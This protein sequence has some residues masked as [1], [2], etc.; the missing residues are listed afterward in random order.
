MVA[1]VSV[2]CRCGHP[3]SNLIA[4]HP[5]GTVDTYFYLI[6]HHLKT[7]NGDGTPIDDEC[8]A[9]PLSTA[10]ALFNP[11]HTVLWRN[12]S[13]C[14]AG[15]KFGEEDCY[16]CKGGASREQT[17][18]Q[19]GWVNQCFEEASRRGPYTHYIRTRPDLYIGAP[20][21]QWAFSANH[22]HRLWTA[23]K[24]APGSDMFFIVSE[25]LMARWWVGWWRKQSCEALEDRSAEYVLFHTLTAGPIRDVPG[26]CD[27]RRDKHV[28]AC[29]DE[30]PVDKEPTE[31]RG[32]ALV[33][34]QGL[35]QRDVIVHQLWGLRVIIVRSNREWS[36]YKSGFWCRPLDQDALLLQLTEYSC[37][38]NAGTVRCRNWQHADGC[39]EGPY[40]ASGHVDPTY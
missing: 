3:P 9:V 11:V 25:E 38:V 5:P 31:E 13:S 12:V 29:V 37:S 32:V 17:Y 16:R 21:P 28:P 20:V 1:F 7:K 18:L 40:P 2:V 33:G 8:S 36:C 10:E 24:Y 26:R 19:L 23:H 4:P 35:F 15:L 6:M 39:P 22:S 30:A 27:D 14:A 34:E